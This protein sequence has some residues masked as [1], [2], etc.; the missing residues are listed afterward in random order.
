[1]EWNESN[2]R[3]F[4]EKIKTKDIVPI[5]GPGVFKVLDNNEVKEYALQEYI[6]RKVLKN[7]Y[8]KYGLSIIEP[9][10]DN[11]QQLCDGYRGMSKLARML[12]VYRKNLNR[13]VIE[14]YDSPDFQSNIVLDKEVKDF[15]LRGQFPLIITTCGFIQLELL[16][17]KYKSIVYQLG[18]TEDQRLPNDLVKNPSIFHIFGIIKRNK[19]GVITEKEFLNF[20]SHIKDSKTCPLVGEDK[21]G[22]DEY[23]S[24]NNDEKYLLTIGCEIP[25]WTFRFLLSSLKKDSYGELLSG[26]QYDDTFYGGSFMP[27][28]DEDLVFFL[29]DIGYCSD[30]ELNGFLKNVNGELPPPTEKP[31]VFLSVNSD[32]YHTYGDKLKDKL[33][34]DY[35]VWFFPDDGKKRYWAS[36]K[37][38]LS[39]CQYFIP[40]IT[41]QSIVKLGIKSKA[42]EPDK[43]VGVITEYRMALEEMKSRSSGELFSIPY[44][45]ETNVEVLKGKLEEESCPNKD[46]FP[47]FFPGNEALPS[48]SIEDF[49]VDILNNYIKQA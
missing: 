23:L 21:R 20:L 43:E 11:I 48:I 30:T 42:P 22:L 41:N 12:G 9:S 1:M 17:P 34:V 40:L 45:I 10:D 44:V 27:E 33:Q 28:K 8:G 15:L 47:L 25:D 4:V 13:E 29:D 3:D 16:L 38:A 31:K 6:V 2:V 35:D 14:I 32:E 39:E 7:V 18:S 19:K 24:D 49:S 46:L 37:K 36:I 26:G 5:I